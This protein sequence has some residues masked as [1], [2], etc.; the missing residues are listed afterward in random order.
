MRRTVLAAVAALALTATPAKA[1]FLPH[2]GQRRPPIGFVVGPTVPFVGFGF[3]NYPRPVPL[4]WDLFPPPVVVGPPVIVVG[5]VVE[6]DPNP[7][8]PA[9]A[10]RPDMIVI[11]P[12]KNADP[13]PPNQERTVPHL[14]RIVK[15]NPPGAGPGF[16]G[17]ARS[18]ELVKPKAAPA[19]APPDPA[20]EAVRQAREAFAAE[21]YGRAAERLDAATAAKPAE[22]LPYFLKAQAQFAAGQYAD[23]AAAIR[24]GMGRAPDW[25][26]GGFKPAELYGA[27]PERFAAHLA[28]LRKAVVDNPAEPALAFLLGYE[29]W[30]AGERAEAA[31]QFRAAAAKAGRDGPLAERFLREADRGK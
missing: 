2:P 5:G 16:E 27:N 9:A 19:K 30:F 28:E 31:K 3:G 14:D 12:R 23:A 15:P 20:A 26:T 21:Q 4:G 18:S 8:V 24:T 29:L 6:D 1:Q 7:V 10:K 13:F 22:A 17:F 25:P 11:G